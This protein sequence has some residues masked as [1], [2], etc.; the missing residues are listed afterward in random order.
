M[1]LAPYLWTVD[2]TT[3]NT[4]RRT[5]EPSALYWFGTD[6]LGRDIYSRVVYGAGAVSMD[7]RSDHAEHLAPHTRAFRA[8]LVRHRHAR[9]RYLLARRLWCW[10]RIYGPSI[11]PR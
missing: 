3:L 5:R 10:R 4:S 8:L 1:V 11:R 2:P 9:A 7:R 6:M